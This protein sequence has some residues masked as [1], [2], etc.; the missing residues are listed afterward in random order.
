MFITPHN[1]VM[2]A[3]NTLT[4]LMIICTKVLEMDGQTT[5]KCPETKLTH[6]SDVSKKKSRLRKV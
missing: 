3:T 4:H 5:R 1:K 2:E 6:I